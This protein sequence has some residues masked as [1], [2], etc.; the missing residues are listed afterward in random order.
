MSTI[1][2]TAIKYYDGLYKIY[3]YKDN[4][5]GGLFE[6]DVTINN[7]GILS[8]TSMST[9]LV[10]GA[11]AILK[12]IHTKWEPLDIMHR[13]T[14]TAVLLDPALQIGN[15][16]D[17]FE[18]VF[19]G[20]FETGDLSEWTVDGA[21]LAIQKLGPI[22]PTH[23][24]Y[25]A[26]CG[27]GPDYNKITSLSKV[28]KIQ[29]GVTTLPISMDFNFVTEEYPEYVNAGYNDSVSITLKDDTGNE[30]FTTVLASV[31]GSA[32]CP[33]IITED[34][35]PGNGDITAGQTGWKTVGAV[36]N[37][38][39]TGGVYQIDIS[40]DIKTDGDDDAYDS[41][42]L[43]DHIQLEYALDENPRCGDE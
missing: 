20:S 43:I 1:S 4:L 24:D 14:Q 29:P 30:I 2:D 11:A 5:K 33:N 25:M 6:N 23:R 15:R 38:P 41:G 36:F 17:I 16:L 26:I 8:G 18:A 32:F 31:D 12:T 21:C 28:L 7:Y 39:D 3:D 27:S 22:T 42:I 40:F 13:L 10:S 9:P 35:A 37:I 19:N 34:L